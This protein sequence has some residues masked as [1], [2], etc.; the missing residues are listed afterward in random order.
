MIT[1]YFSIYFL[2]FCKMTNWQHKYH[3]PVHKISEQLS[4]FEHIAIAGIIIVTNQ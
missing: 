3:K 1:Y 4:A 2:F